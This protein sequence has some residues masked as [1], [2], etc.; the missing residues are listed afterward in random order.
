MVIKQ[1]QLTSTEDKAVLSAQCKIRK[2]GW[3]KIFFS[4]DKQYK[5]YLCDDASP[6]AA[7]LLL[8]AMKV[9]EDLIIK[10]SISRKLYD[11]MHDIMREVLSWEIDIGLKPIKVH[12]DRLT[13][14][15]YHPRH[16]ACFFSSGVDSFYTYLKHKKDTDQKGK[17]DTLIFVNNSFDIDPRNRRLWEQTLDNIRA[18]AKAER[19]DLIVAE[20]NIYTH[21][22]LAPI[23]PWEYIHGGCLAAAGLALRANLRR[24]YISSTFSDEEQVPWGTHPNLDKHW[25]TETVRFQHD[26]NEATRINKVL[27]QVAKSPLALKH[28][29]VCYENEAGTFNCGRCTKCLRT[30][31]NL[32][33]ADAL[34]KAETFPHTIDLALVAAM[35]AALAGDLVI[36]PCEEQNLDV[37]EQRNL[38]PKLQQAIRY[39]ITRNEAYHKRR[40]TKLKNKFA[41]SVRKLVYLDHAYSR[42]QAYTILSS[43]F[44]RKFA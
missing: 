30:M 18:I 42:G 28:L 22:L 4:V 15:T 26:G 44:G 41:K 35:P 29:K 43:L 13:T 39:S 37:L 16:T 14:D 3:D 2:F 32:F 19:L 31:T 21:S 8:P 24:V 5:D 36:F 6:F 25:S 38:A 17:V 11:G 20:S 1:I 7:T 40:S 10:G 34:D 9:G 23:L 33:A 12:A 27:W